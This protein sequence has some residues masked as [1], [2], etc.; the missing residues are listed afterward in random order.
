MSLNNE[1]CNRLYY[2]LY[3]GIL[4]PIYVQKIGIWL[5]FSVTYSIRSNCQ[6]DKPPV[7]SRLSTRITYQKRLTI[8][9]ADEAKAKSYSQGFGNCR[10]PQ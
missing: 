7:D 8:T 5:T 3:K 10:P 9:A 2:M 6:N 1:K 4:I